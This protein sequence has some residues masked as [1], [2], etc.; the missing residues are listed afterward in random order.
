MAEEIEFPKFIMLTR[1]TPSAHIFPPGEPHRYGVEL[2]AFFSLE[3]FTAYA[4]RE[5]LSESKFIGVWELG[6]PIPISVRPKTVEVEK[7]EWTI[8]R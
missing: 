8:S 7:R 5:N 6:E 1:G 2:K 3:D 4:E